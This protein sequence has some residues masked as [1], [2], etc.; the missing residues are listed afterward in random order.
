VAATQAAEHVPASCVC[1]GDII[2]ITHEGV[3]VIVAVQG[4][5]HGNTGR[6]GRNFVALKCRCR[7]GS[8]FTEGVASA[9]LVDRISEGM[10]AEVPGDLVSGRAA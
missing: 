4:A 3:S 2:V 5:T 10:C 6:F 1:A 7:D 8:E 9:V